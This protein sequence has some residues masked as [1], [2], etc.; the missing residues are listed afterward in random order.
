MKNKKINIIEIG[1]RYGESSI[2]M[3]NNL[4]INKYIIIDPYESYD[5]YKSDDFNN[6]IKD[7]EDIIFNDINILLKNKFPNIDIVFYRGY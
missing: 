1:A 2:I 6:I 7:K 3:M 5:E 4:N